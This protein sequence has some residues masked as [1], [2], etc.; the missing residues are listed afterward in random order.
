MWLQVICPLAILLLQA[1]LC[2][3]SSSDLQRWQ[4][5]SMVSRVYAAVKAASPMVVKATLTW[6][7]H[8]ACWVNGCAHLVL[9]WSILFE[10]LGG[11][12]SSGVC[13]LHPF[14]LRVTPMA[15]SIERQI[16][17]QGVKGVGGSELLTGCKGSTHGSHCDCSDGIAP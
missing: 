15:H 7:M 9:R 4:R 11:I 5:P 10:V 1:A 12:C 13:A 14:V 17:D 6:L 2:T 3:W 16:H 8:G